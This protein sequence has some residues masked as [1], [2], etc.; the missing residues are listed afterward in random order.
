MTGLWRD[1]TSHG[2]YGSSQRS[3]DA[4]AMREWGAPR[5]MARRTD[6]GCSRAG[7]RGDQRENNCNE[8]WHIPPQRFL[9]LTGQ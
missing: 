4:L 5:S 7:H 3:I 1:G 6:I 9:V 2:H 8:N